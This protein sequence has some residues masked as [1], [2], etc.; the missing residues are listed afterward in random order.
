M[1]LLIDIDRGFVLIYN[2]FLKSFDC[3]NLV[4]VSHLLSVILL[5]SLLNGLNYQIAFVH[6]LGGQIEIGLRIPLQD[7]LCHV[8][9]LEIERFLLVTRDT[10]TLRRVLIM[11]MTLELIRI[12][13]S[14]RGCSLLK[15]VLTIENLILSTFSFQSQLRFLPENSLRGIMLRL[16]REYWNKL[17][18]PNGCV[19][20]LLDFGPLNVFFN[21]GVLRIDQLYD[22]LLLIYT[23]SSH[24]L[25]EVTV[26]VT[27]LKRSQIV[28]FHG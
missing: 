19:N 1:I 16:V 11:M 7:R 10:L 4:C 27:G 18:N 3:Y 17:W 15:A 6:S 22:G 20:F 9:N 13:S 2:G 25:F 8:M 12:Q 26:R 21:Y 14:S 28:V 5:N 23:H 24:W